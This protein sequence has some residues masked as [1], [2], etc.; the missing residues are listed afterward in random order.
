[1]VCAIPNP[2]PAPAWSPE[3]QAASR[4]VSS[5]PLPV[6]VIVMPTPQMLLG[7]PTEHEAGSST[8]LLD[9]ACRGVFGAVA[10]DPAGGP[11][12]VKILPPHP[13]PPVNPGES[14]M[15][16]LWAGRRE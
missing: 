16:L 1:V 6:T 4:T 5:I 10:G 13:R 12:I 7:F 15:W 2:H 3:S 8:H 9:C 14:T 11:D